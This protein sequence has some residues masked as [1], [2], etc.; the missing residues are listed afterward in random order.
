LNNF[1]F[2]F[3][4][5]NY[6]DDVKRLIGEPEMTRYKCTL[7]VY[8]VIAHCEI[9][10]AASGYQFVIRNRRPIDGIDLIH[11]KI[12][13]ARSKSTGDRH[14]PSPP[15]PPINRRS[16][17]N[18]T[19]ASESPENISGVIIITPKSQNRSPAGMQWPIRDPL[20]PPPPRVRRA[21]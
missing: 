19:W 9:A 14:S 13:V 5:I 2:P 7:I 17:D 4:L 10:S 15:P 18:R 11:A 12:H 8:L 3:P 16:A 1:A 20:R 6:A 21:P